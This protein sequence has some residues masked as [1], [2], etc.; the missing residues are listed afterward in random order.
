MKQMSQNTKT[1][2]AIAAVV[3]LAIAF[4]FLLLAPKQEKADELASQAKTLRTEVAGEQQRVE[5]GLAA[6]RTFAADYQQLVLLGK[7]VPAEAATPSLLVQLNNVSASADTSFNSI[8]LEEDEG[9]ETEAAPEATSEA[10]A[11]PT[12]AAAALLPIGAAVGPAGLPAL[13]YKLEFNGDYF[14]IADFLDGLDDLV[15]TRNGLVD[16][17]GRLVTIDSFVLDPLVTLKGR[18]ILMGIF[19]VTTYSTPPDEGLTAGAT[20]AGPPPAP[21]PEE[22]P[23]SLSQP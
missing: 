10:A 8:E 7:A 14:D 3:A 17:D 5:S 15:E 1:A 16:A 13:P 12:E 4:W 11:A 23:T 9:G 20:E 19:N 21:A 22:T 18:T 6:K 2:L